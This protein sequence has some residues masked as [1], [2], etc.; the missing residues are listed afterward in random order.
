MIHVNEVLV[1]EGKYDRQTLARFVD[2]VIVET[3]G[4]GIFQDREKLE[5]LR[6][7]AKERGLILLTDS[8]RSGLA[9]RNYLLGAIGQGSVRNAYIPDLYG[10]EKRKAH[11]SKEGKIGVEGMTEEV[12]RQILAFA[13]SSPPERDPITNADLYAVGLLGGKDSSARRAAYQKQ[14]GLPAHLSPKKFLEVLNVMRSSDEF[15]RD[16]EETKDEV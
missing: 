14:L 9:I 16:F 4:F 10:K 11:P 13:V 8:D 5:L 15:Y 12:L 3:D 6:T 2:G 1:V 7:L